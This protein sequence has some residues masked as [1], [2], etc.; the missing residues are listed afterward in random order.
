MPIMFNESEETV[1]EDSHEVQRERLHQGKMTRL[2]R[3]A[4]HGDKEAKEQ[5]LCMMMRFLNDY[6][7]S[8]VYS[9][10]DRDD[11][12]QESLI[13]L[14][15]KLDEGDVRVASVSAWAYKVAWQMI[16][17]HRSGEYRCGKRR[18]LPGISY[19]AIEIPISAIWEEEEG[20]ENDVDKDKCIC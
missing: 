11:L 15:K 16:G 14:S 4:A 7:G 18:Q 19:A 5:L 12:V 6:I 20:V 2:F 3:L 17:R 8:H 13:I 1:T 9:K 10:A